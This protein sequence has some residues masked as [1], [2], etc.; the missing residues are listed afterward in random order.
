MKY[1][2]LTYIKTVFIDADDTV[3]DF[4]KAQEHAF[5]AAC[6]KLGIACTKELY[7]DYDEINKFYWKMFERKEIE[8][9][10][11]IFA[12]FED[13]FA[14]H[15]FAASAAEMEYAYQD[16]LGEQYFFV[17]GA[18]DGIRYL[19]RKYKLY[20][21]TNGL[22]VTQESRIKNSGFIN[23]VDGVFISEEVGVGKPDKAYFDYVFERT[24]AEKSTSIIIG[25]SLTS[26][27]A[28]GKNAGITTAWYNDKRKPVAPDIC[29]DFVLNDW[30]EVL[31]LL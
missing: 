31:S 23:F 29:P 18:Y 14:K 1:E 6:K 4:G 22:K 28:G 15:G 10:R 17:E 2:K 8:K 7:A 24:G 12:R 9:S 30:D 26:D 20:V 21:V 13:F 27:I 3:L 25:D 5:F 11:L 16:K 19:H